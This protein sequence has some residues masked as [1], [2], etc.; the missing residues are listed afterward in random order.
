MDGIECLNCGH[1][2]LADAI[3][4]EECGVELVRPAPEP[5]P[6]PVLEQDI[7][8]KSVEAEPE[9]ML[10]SVEDPLVAEREDP[11]FPQFEP[12][13]EADDLE[14]NELSGGDA[15]EPEEMDMDPGSVTFI[16]PLPSPDLPWQD[17]P[18]LPLSQVAVSVETEDPDPLAADPLAE[19]AIEEILSGSEHADLIEPEDVTGETADDPD[20]VS[21][22]VDV[23]PNP[24]DPVIDPANE[25]MPLEDPP[26]SD[27]MAN[28][29]T[30]LEPDS[31]EPEPD[32]TPD[33]EAAVAM[34]D[35]D[36][37][38]GTVLDMPDEPEPEPA[39]PE[40]K[41]PTA[42]LISETGDRFEL[43]MVPILYLGKPN[44]EIPVQ[45]DL[46]KVTESEIISRVHAVIHRINRDDQPE[47]FYLE[48]AGSLNGTILNGEPLQ[49]GTR[50]RK[51]LK[52]GDTITLGRKRQI[53]FRFQIEIE[54]LETEALP[55]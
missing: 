31:P 50:H 22:V 10:D 54:E 28:V 40:P 15:E 51:L 17:T 16:Q 29:G 27:P 34:M 24:E 5:L 49:A 32:R 21:D 9:P 36:Q 23:D 3:Y 37:N 45:V 4:C 55:E 42:W 39:P 30:D 43:P 52:S 13:S 18:D 38:P 14:A 41:P 11:T 7:S 33:P 44:D 19:V 6:E 46:S 48:D 1:L 25:P 47:A 2:N 20:P 53:N 8:V 26:I 35:F 12:G